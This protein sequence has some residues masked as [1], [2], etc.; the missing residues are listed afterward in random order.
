[1]LYNLLKA[2]LNLN[3]SLNYT[4]GMDSMAAVALVASEYKVN[5]DISKLYNFII[6][7]KNY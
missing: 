7:S 5:F 3:P 2:F 4:Q 6:N 1:M